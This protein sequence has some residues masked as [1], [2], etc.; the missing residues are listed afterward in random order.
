MKYVNDL[1]TGSVSPVGSVSPCADVM[2]QEEVDQMWTYAYSGLS[3]KEKNN[4]FGKLGKVVL[5]LRRR[6]SR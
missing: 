2:T 3:R 4:W 1:F 6:I 5:S